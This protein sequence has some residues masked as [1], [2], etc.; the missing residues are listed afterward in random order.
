[1]AID[2]QA[3]SEKLDYRVALR[4]FE[5]A[6]VVCNRLPGEKREAVFH[7]AARR[8]LLNMP[9]ESSVAA[10]TTKKAPVS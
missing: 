7:E 5:A 2:K 4:L 10:A 8:M 6:F 9:F 3:F 1:M